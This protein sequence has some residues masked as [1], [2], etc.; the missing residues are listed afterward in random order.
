MD[1]PSYLPVLEMWNAPE[2]ILANTRVATKRKQ[3][4]SH[5]TP[6]LLDAIRDALANGE[7][8]ILFQ[9]RRGYSNYIVCIDCGHIPKCGRCDVS[10]TYHRISGK[11]ECHYCGHKESMPHGCPSCSNTNMMHEG[12]WDRKD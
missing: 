4:V 5:F 6:Q 1:L 8:V 12:F 9:N 10:L 2:I 7:Q 3:M 11:L